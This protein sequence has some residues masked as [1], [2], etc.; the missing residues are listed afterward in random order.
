MQGKN[1]GGNVSTKAASYLPNHCREFILNASLAYFLVTQ[2]M[3]I[4]INPVKNIVNLGL[5]RISHDRK[6][7]RIV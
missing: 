6:R 4:S 1:L 7:K 2:S 5:T 3:T